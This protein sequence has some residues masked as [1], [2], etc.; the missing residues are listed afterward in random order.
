MARVWRN[1]VPGF[2]A[3]D[4]D[5][6]DRFACAAWAAVPNLVDGGPGLVIDWQQ[7]SGVLLAG[8]NSAQL[9][10]WDLQSEQ[11]LCRAAIGS[12]PFITSMATIVD[13]A[14]GGHGENLTICGC[15]D[16]TLRLFDPRACS[17]HVSPTSHSLCTPPVLLPTF[18]AS[19]PPVLF[20]HFVPF[21]RHFVLHGRA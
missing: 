8:G 14:H 1:P 2:A 11:C 17:P 6:G 4:D 16:G 5:C 19:P 15:G 18:R 10:M 7:R 12:A 21:F 13:A 20:R 9:R 3:S